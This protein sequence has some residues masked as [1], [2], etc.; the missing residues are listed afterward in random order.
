LPAGSVFLP[1]PYRCAEIVAALWESDRHGLINRTRSASNFC[2]SLETQTSLA[3][4]F[5][6]TSKVASGVSSA[7]TVQQIEAK[8]A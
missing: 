5:G 8:A 3:N 2:L 7:N 6:V 1:K 4:S